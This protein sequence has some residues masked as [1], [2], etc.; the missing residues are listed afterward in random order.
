MT[1]TTPHNGRLCNQIIRNLA[2]SLIATKHDLQVY[3]SSKDRM[4]ALGIQLFCGKTA[5]D[6]T[7]LLNDNNYLAI[8]NSDASLNSNLDPNQA[9][10]QTKDICA[11]LYDYVRE[12]AQKS[13]IIHCNPFQFRYNANNDLFIHVRLTDAAHFNPGLDYYLNAIKQIEFEQLFISTDDTS[14]PMISEIMKSTPNSALFN[15]SEV[16]TIQFGSTC[17]HILLSHGSFSAM[18]G[19]LAFFSN[20]HYPVYDPNKIW[21]GDMFSVDGWIK[22]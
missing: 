2:V 19:Y 22:H 7:V 9:Y 10:F 11:V 21:Y 14:H 17:K 18:I 4:D 15:A 13:H 20:V 1:T 16:N 3:Y 6:N 12:D 8:L 5:H